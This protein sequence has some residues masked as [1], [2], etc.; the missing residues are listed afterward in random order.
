MPAT[1]NWD[2]ESIHDGAI[3]S[4]GMTD[5]AEPKHLATTV[6]P[7]EILLEILG[8]L[9][10]HDI[11]ILSSVNRHLYETIPTVL[12]YNVAQQGLRI[13]L[14]SKNGSST[15]ALLASLR[16]IRFDHPKLFMYA[17][18]AIA[19]HGISE[20]IAEILW[21]KNWDSS[22]SKSEARRLDRVRMMKLAV[23]K[24]PWP[25]P[26]SRRFQEDLQSVFRI[27]ALLHS[28]DLLDVLR[29]KFLKNNHEDLGT[30]PMRSFFFSSAR[31]GFADGLSL[32][33]I[34]DPMFAVPRDN[35]V[36]IMHL[37]VASKQTAAA[38][39]LL[40]KG[41]LA[42]STVSSNQYKIG[43]PLHEAVSASTPA[44][45]L[46]LLENGAD[47]EATDLNRET[48]LHRA[49]K[50]GRV[51][52]ARMLLA[53]GS[54]TN[55]INWNGLGPIHVAAALGRCDLI[56][57]LLASGVDVDAKDQLGQTALAHA[58]Q[59]GHV[60]AAKLL[61]TK[62][63]SVDTVTG[64]GSVLHSALACK[65]LEILQL[66]VDAG[67]PL[68]QVNG[69]GLSALHCALDIRSA[70]AAK[71]LLSAGANPNV[72]GLWGRT[73]L[74]ILADKLVW[75]RPVAEVVALME[76]RSID[77]NVV[78]GEGNTALHVAAARKK[79]QLL[80]WLLTRKGIDK[81]TRDRSGKTWLDVAL[82]NGLKGWLEE[83]IAEL[84]AA[85][86]DLSK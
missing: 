50:E 12:D 35:G 9:H 49:V 5:F 73:A 84:T 80:L 29:R 32:I 81:S 68:N 82:D 34:N 62:G 56:N 8:R 46:L 71:I 40:E 30:L 1:A 16:R 42:P 79:K 52:A 63:V 44:I 65:N 4:I 23:D 6:F 58:C 51:D 39:V 45:L 26:Q 24:G 55:P 17:V 37:A 72:L 25:N 11:P 22:D 28:M 54:A 74:H 20:Q 83:N 18:A 69:Y 38:R 41:A 70:Q 47:T 53:A 10:P 67:A 36:R 76:E 64:L 75:C 19:T 33:P 77:L 21:G 66:V 57:L 15:K 13:A 3:D 61:I 31:A 86:V 59:D 43:S 2:Q 27:A 14:T 85:G 60:D 48:P 78:D 7:A